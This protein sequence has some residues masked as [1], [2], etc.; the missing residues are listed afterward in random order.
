MC[1]EQSN[2]YDAIRVIDK[3]TVAVYYADQE[4]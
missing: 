2:N 1:G 4:R 3:L